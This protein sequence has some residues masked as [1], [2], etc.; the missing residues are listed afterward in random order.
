MEH[1]E[2]RKLRE[3][4]NQRASEFKGKEIMSMLSIFRVR[5]RHIRRKTIAAALTLCLLAAV[6]S[7]C[8]TGAGKEPTKISFKSAVSYDYLKS[9]N[10]K[11]VSIN[12]YLA[13]SSPADGS[14]IFLM[15][16]PYQSCPFCKPNTSQLS[17]TMEVYPKSGRKFD[18]TSQAVNV[19]GTLQVAQDE[20]EPFTDLYGYEFNFKIVDAEFTIITDSEMTA[21]IALW[22][23]IADSGV[24]NEI[25][26][27]YDYLNFVTCWPSYFVNSMTDENGNTVPG[28]YLYASD[29]L[30]FLQ[31]DGAQWNYGYREGYFDGIVSS[32]ERLDATAFSALVENVRKAEKLANRA[33]QELLDGNYTSELKYVEEF[34]Q[35]DYIYTL[36]NGEELSRENDELY[37]EFADWLSTWEM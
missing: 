27:M 33:V 16:L 22:Q 14:F 21:E 8:D 18:Y 36:N 4:G 12:G 9:L 13:T 25:Y 31:T 1:V 28:Y 17:N 37:Y 3:I 7:G 30:M 6:L 19:V 35:E 32:I 10:G 11:P 34:G 24:I 29:A 20:N 2:E 26:A 23:K 15:N 5:N